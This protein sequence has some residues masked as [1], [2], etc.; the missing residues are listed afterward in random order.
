MKTCSLVVAT[1]HSSVASAAHEVRPRLNHGGAGWKHR[2]WR[3]EKDHRGKVEVR[4]EKE[5]R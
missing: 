4:H 2:L 5:T 1:V 3:L